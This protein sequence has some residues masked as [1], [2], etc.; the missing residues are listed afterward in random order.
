MSVLG[1]LL[2]G[3]LQGLTEFMPVSSS[4]H[5][6]IAQ[7]II[8]NFKQPGVLFDVVLHLATTFAVIIFFR[9]KIKSIF[10]SDK[11]YLWLLMVGTIPAALFGIL[12]SDFFERM[13]LD[14]RGTAWQLLLTGI[15]C[16]MIDK[17]KDKAKLI[18]SK[19]SLFIGIAQAIS[20]IPGI[21]RSA[22]TIFAGS[23]LGINKKN[24][25]QYSFLLSIPAIL[26]ANLL[27][28][29]KYKDSLEL[30]TFEYLVGFLAALL[31]GYLSIKVVLAT[32]HKKQFKYFGIYCIILGILVLVII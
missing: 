7:N 21:S 22:S 27:Q 17:F 31:F 1:A 29:I 14:I 13:F 16:F 19:N 26:G 30:Q 10:L 12:F 28:F 3:I 23:L 11:K 6:V 20:I 4:G 24:V 18:N 5:L 8:P 32:L 15:L 9:Q 2:L 25:A